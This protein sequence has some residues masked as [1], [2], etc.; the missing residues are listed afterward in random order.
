MPLAEEIH[1]LADLVPP[2]DIGLWLILLGALL[3]AV[4]SL[5]R[6][7]RLGLGGCAALLYVAAGAAALWPLR[8]RALPAWLQCALAAALLVVAVAYGGAE[9][10]EQGGEDARTARVSRRYLVAMLL[11]AAVLLFSDLG[12][13]A[14]DTLTWEGEVIRG[15]G[16]QGFSGAFRD[17]ES[18][19][20]FTGRSFLWGEGLMSSASDS[21]FYGA[22]TY[23]IFRLVGVSPWTLRVSSAVAAL[24]FIFVAF[25]F[26]RRFLGSLVGV[27]LAGLLLID[28]AVIFYGRYGSSPAGT[29]LAVLLA[30]FATWWFLDGKR[31]AWWRAIPC[32]AALF[33]A[34]LQYSPARLVVLTL[35][36]FIALTTL[37][38]WRTFGWSRAVGVVI[39]AA[40]VW[41]VWHFESAYDR[42]RK[43]LSARG[44]HYFAMLKT[45]SVIDSLLGRR[46]REGSPTAAALTLPKKV[47]LLV[48]LLQKTIPEYLSVMLPSPFGGAW[49]DR[50]VY[51]WDPPLLQ[52]YYPPAALFIGWGLLFSLWRWRDWKYQCFLLW[53]WITVPLLLTNRVD[54]HRLVL[55]LVPLSV[56]GALGV[57]EAARLMCRAGVP[58]AAQHV[59]A[60]GLILAGVLNDV[61]LLIPELPPRQSAS[62]VLLE[63]VMRVPGAVRVGGDWDHTGRALVE[64]GLI[65]RMRRAPQWEADML[66]QA[67]IENVTSRGRRDPSELYL[68]KLSRDAEKSTVFLAPAKHFKKVGQAM[69]ASGLRVAEGGSPEL[70]FLRIDAGAEATGVAD[71]E[72]RPLPTIHVPPTPT[73]IA[74]LTGSQVPLT[75]LEPQEVK[76]G[77]QEPDYRR[78]DSGHQIVMGGV[79]YASGIFT[80]A[81]M[82]MT[83]A[84]PAGAR[85]FQ[86]IVGIA[87]AVKD[88]E[89]AAVTFE[90]RGPGDELLFDSGL[91]DV[92]S[93]PR[94]I[95]VEV[96]HVPRITLVATEAGNGRDCDHAEWAL[97]SFVM[98]E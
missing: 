9:E 8:Y 70:R 19:A 51:T 90:V 4:C 5:L 63:E 53:L 47:E 45:P 35:L 36:G 24:L 29:L 83:Y 76:F 52:L 80:H 57:R 48:E 67:V 82:K 73:P 13:Y 40:A 43:F 75:D 69:Q 55:F 22:P 81:W 95:L 18:V 23:A 85:W 72:V 87:D 15:E 86:A 78:N 28:P 94:P 50:L 91:M 34:T 58:V 6:G 39:I 54:A 92:S 84:V 64:L 41:G 33:V 79:S 26:G 14:G 98:A 62:A 25:A 68:R 44:E 17:G 60:C 93:P 37:V 89:Q 20:D 71:A 31:S 66:P 74:L 27:A 12:G 16:I 21:L 3:T 96:G 2:I 38:Q 49:T 56:W 97:P 42:E 30:V 77:F 65:E 59:L 1:R 11:L 46:G 10:N 61:N 7:R 88:C 32:A